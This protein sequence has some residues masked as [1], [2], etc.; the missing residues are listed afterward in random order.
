M[1][2]QIRFRGVERSEALVEYTTHRAH[3]HLRRFEP[4]L[5]G[6]MIRITDLNGPRG[7]KDKRC[8]FTATGPAIGSIHLSY[9]HKDVYAGVDI[10]LEKMSHLIVRSIERARKGV[11]ATGAG[12]GQVFS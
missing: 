8:Q 3:Q 1:K 5:S 2:I 6:V 11:V 4:Q 10:G 9:T 12:L 7:G